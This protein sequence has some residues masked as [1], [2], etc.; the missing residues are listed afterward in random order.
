M[1]KVLPRVLCCLL[2]AS[3]LPGCAWWQ[4]R[5]DKKRQVAM[6]A[7]V[8]ANRERPQF[9]GKVT[10]VNSEAGFV[11][12]DTAGTQNPKEGTTVRTYSDGAS[13]AELRT[14]GVNRRSFLIADVVSGSPR[15]DDEVW[16]E[17]LASPTA[18]PRATAVVHSTPAPTARKRSWFSR[19]LPRF[20]RRE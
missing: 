20:V 19:M 9:I 15:R 5:G 1:M 10:L 12:I 17:P 13:S 2:V 14:T 18:I 11:L 7:R 3:V 8:R 16:Q 6:E 4:K